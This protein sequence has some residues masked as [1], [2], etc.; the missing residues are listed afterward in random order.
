MYDNPESIR[1]KSEYVK[2][3]RLGGVA[4]WSVDLD[5]FRGNMCNSGKYPL[6]TALNQYLLG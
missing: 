1:Y 6:L 4:Y 3:Q 2:K 5:D